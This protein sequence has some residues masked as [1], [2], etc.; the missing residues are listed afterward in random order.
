MFFREI[1]SNPIEINNFEARRWQEATDGYKNIF[2]IKKIA[3]EIIKI[4][5]I[6]A[7][8]ALLILIVQ[9]VPVPII[10][11]S[12]MLIASPFILGI[13]TALV[14]RKISLGSLTGQAWK[15]WKDEVNPAVQ[16]SK[17]TTKIFMVPYLYFRD[18]FDLTPYHDR[19]EATHISMRL[20]Q[21]SLA[22]LVKHHGKR[23]DNLERYGFIDQIQLARVR[24][25]YNNY[26]P[27][28]KA[29]ND[30]EK[31]HKAVLSEESEEVQ[32]LVYPWEFERRGLQLNRDMYEDEWKNLQRSFN[33]LILA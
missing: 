33:P 27:N 1:N 14:D 22:E 29:L 28:Q 19:D 25:I 5:N 4:L 16:I 9:S 6:A 3:L 21:R 7:I 8:L 15:S 20:T 2:T 13:L 24:E 26:V 10:P 17:H 18:R 11:L 31:K 30:L 12:D 23:L 32:K